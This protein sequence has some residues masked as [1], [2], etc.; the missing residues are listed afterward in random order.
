MEMA[1]LRQMDLFRHLNTVQLS[2]VASITHEVALPKGE[3]LFREGDA[4]EELFIIVSG[5]VRI[6][7]IV[8]SIGEEALAI[9]PAGSYFGEMELIESGLT[10]AAQAS[11]HEDCILRRM[12]YN[13][14]LD[15]LRSDSE[16][17][18][19]F[20]W[21]IVKTLSERL[22]ETDDKVTAMFALAQ[23]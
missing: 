22:R 23:F 4:A 15:M 20:L 10:R 7:K 5:R 6:S 3:I 11:A 19:A 18:Q 12:A 13:E 16:L 17:A 21:S 14:F 9:L 1:I 8:P 2:H